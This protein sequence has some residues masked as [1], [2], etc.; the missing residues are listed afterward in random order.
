MS[1]KIAFCTF[2]V[3][4]LVILMR[5]VPTEAVTL[6]VGPGAGYDYRDLGDA[7]D[8][9]RDG[10]EIVVADG[11]YTGRDNR[12]L[13]FDGKVIV[14]RS[15]NGP[16]QCIVDCQEN[17]PAFVFDCESPQAVLQGF[18]FVNGVSDDGGAIAIHLRAPLIR[19]CVFRTNSASRDGGAIYIGPECGDVKLINCQF[20]DNEAKDDGGAIAKQGNGALLLY[21]CLF[22]GTQ[23]RDNGGAVFCRDGEVMVIACRFYG[24][25]AR[26]TGA[27]MYNRE[28]D[29]ILI[30]S[31]F[32]GNHAHD[33]GGGLYC[34]ATDTAA[35]I[36]H[37]TFYGNIAGLEGGGIAS[38]AD[39]DVAYVRG[40]ILWGNQDESGAGWTAQVNGIVPDAY[41]SCIQGWTIQDPSRGNVTANPLCMDP[42]GADDVI[43]TVDDN[44]NLSPDSPC[45]DAAGLE[46]VSPP[47]TTD[48]QGRARVCGTAIDMGA[49]EFQPPDLNAPPAVDDIL[50]PPVIV[51]EALNHS[52]GGPDWVELHNLSN[53]PVYVGGWFLSD[54]PGTPWKYQIASGTWI[55]PNGYMVLDQDLHFGN[56]QDPGARLTFGFSSSGEEICLSSGAA[57]IPTGYRQVHMLPAAPRGVA[58][59]RCENSL[60]VVDFMLTQANTPGAENSGIQIGPV[61]ISEV[62]YELG[63]M[64][65][66]A[67]YVEL[68][69]VSDAAVVLEPGDANEPY[70]L[71]IGTEYIFPRD[72]ATALAP[73]GRLLIAK[74]PDVLRATYPTI[75]EGT[76]ILGPYE[77]I[78]PH[79]D[80]LVELQRYNMGAWNYVCL[81]RIVYNTDGTV[82]SCDE[83]AW[84]P[85]WPQE[86]YGQGM[87]LTRIDPT[88]YGNE[89]ANWQAA[90]P[91]P[92]Y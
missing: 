90:P 28:N 46:V 49:L 86:A 50:T 24:N 14:L 20:H 29:P 84:Q 67:Q 15:A 48:V 40:C 55:D 11:V 92:G 70:R 62:M 72:P 77:G 63:S 80:G 51:T 68:W 76:V 5:S 19:D 2:A 34:R 41:A 42:D 9:A 73:N 58:N 47:L 85:Y 69:N 78:L 45:V 17:D 6:T 1:V 35:L 33:F 43:G 25:V 74:D 53:E 27:G 61:I 13:Y 16:A 56:S 44:L 66:G 31:L 7:I 64:G 91:T 8:D 79:N 83:F 32:S 60:G 75:P 89:P 82:A 4:C 59:A 30:N 3:A 71:W 22:V 57:G 26:S 52:G 12:D 87:S 54:D 39:Q 37:C 23:G 88:V 38:A 81:D 65:S 10:D 36:L 18:T 21:G